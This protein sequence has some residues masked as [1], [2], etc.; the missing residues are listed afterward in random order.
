MRH[1]SEIARK[2]P[3]SM[4]TQCSIWERILRTSTY[5]FLKQ[6]HITFNDK[7]NKQ[8]S[9][10]VLILYYT[11]L[12]TR[13][14]NLALIQKPDTPCFSCI[15]FC[16][17]LMQP[18]GDF[19]L[20]TILTTLMWTLHLTTIRWHLLFLMYSF[21]KSTEVLLLCYMKNSNIHLADIAS[22][23]V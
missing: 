12:Y 6:G 7:K 10:S 17:S 22:A 20:I 19:S 9:S 15:H 23:G 21:R 11:S 14:V 4:A 13:F 5:T 1:I 18:D 2:Q 3:S 8:I 16:F